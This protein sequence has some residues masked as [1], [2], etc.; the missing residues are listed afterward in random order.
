[1]SGRK[2]MKSIGLIGLGILLGLLSL[3][4]CSGNGA[5]S[6]SV[7]LTTGTV[8][9]SEGGG[10]T[11]G[12]VPV[13]DVLAKDGDFAFA[14]DNRDTTGQRV[15]LKSA[16][17]SIVVEAADE[18]ITAITRMA[19]EMG[20][21]VVNSSTNKVLTSAGQEVARG[22]ITVR[23]PSAR[24]DEA[25]TRIKTG[26]GSVESESV[27]GQDVTQTYI[28]LQSRLTNLEAAEVQLR[29]ILTEARKT[30]DVLAVYSQLVSTR[31]EIETIRGQI[32]YYDEAAAFSAITVDVTPKAIES[33]IQ[34]AGWSPGRTAERALATLV[35]VLQWA[36]DLVIT[37]A[38]LVVPLLLVIGVP[39]W[40]IW[41]RMRRRSAPG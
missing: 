11:A 30:E 37:I 12:E 3:A 15:I 35:N 13:L 33:P 38:L 14:G 26:V 19:E 10:Q 24:L 25:M 16:Y 1:M 27:S 2:F 39:G 22:S 31:G 17:L 21:W 34:I 6:P 8:A 9:Q 5:A 36:A 28:D 4:A 20:G 23:V 29:G 7:S 32:Q 18:T 40:L 41:R